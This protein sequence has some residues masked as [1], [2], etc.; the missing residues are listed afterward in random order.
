MLSAWVTRIRTASP[1]L[2]RLRVPYARD[3]DTVDDVRPGIPEAPEARALAAAI[4]IAINT[5]P[6]DFLIQRKAGGPGP[7]TSPCREENT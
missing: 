1:S 3:G 5:A 7:S 6:L 2:P 4:A